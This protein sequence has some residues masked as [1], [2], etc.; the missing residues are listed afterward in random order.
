MIME[1]IISEYENQIEV[2]KK[3]ISHYKKLYCNEA[4][5]IGSLIII[6]K[7]ELMKLEVAELEW[8]IYCMRDYLKAI[9]KV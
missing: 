3:L 8:N 2:L 6:E 4:S 7:I 1:K 5:H 9:G